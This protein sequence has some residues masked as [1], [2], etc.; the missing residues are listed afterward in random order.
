MDKKTV[1]CKYCRKKIAFYRVEVLLPKLTNR[2]DQEPIEE[3]A[4]KRSLLLFN[5]DSESKDEEAPNKAL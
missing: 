2:T 3:Q 4:R 5:S 1:V